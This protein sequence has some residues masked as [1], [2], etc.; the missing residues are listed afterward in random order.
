MFNFFK[1]KEPKNLKEVLF[2]FENLEKNFKKISQELEN[3][4]KEGKF[5]IQKVGI[6]RYSPFKEVGGNQSFSI[7]LLDGKNTGVVIT[8][9]YNR[10]GSRVYGKSIKSGQSEHLL[11]GEEKEAIEKAISSK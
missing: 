4:K 3:L 2:R 5:S 8:S 10:E 7:A 9:L 1:K 6:I 11:S